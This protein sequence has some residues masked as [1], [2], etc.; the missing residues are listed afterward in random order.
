MNLKYSPSV[1]LNPDAYWLGEM[2]LADDGEVHAKLFRGIEIDKPLKIDKLLDLIRYAA[3]NKIQLENLENVIE[4][5]AV[6]ISNN[7]ALDREK[8]CAKMEA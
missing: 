8:K 3:Q 5:L 7:Y 4:T 6:W 2:E 1:P